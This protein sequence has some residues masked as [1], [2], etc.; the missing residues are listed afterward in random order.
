MHT[1]SA[2]REFNDFLIDDGADSAALAHVE[3]RGVPI[4]VVPTAAPLR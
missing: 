3:D 4:T 2:I 1:L